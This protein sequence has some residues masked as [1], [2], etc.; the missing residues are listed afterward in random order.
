MFSIITPTVGRSTLQKTCESVNDQTCK[1]WEHLV[2]FDGPEQE[3]EVFKKI[4]HPQRR[5][6]FSGKNFGDYG[7]S[8]RFFAWEL[9]KYPYLMYIDDDDYYHQECLQVIKSNLNPDVNFAFF[10]CRRF[11]AKFLKL[12]PRKNATVSCQYVHKKIDEKGSSIRFPPGGHGRD[13]WWIQKM[14]ETYSYQ[15]IDPDC[16]MV[17]VDTI[18]DGAHEDKPE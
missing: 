13:S 18:S 3:I 17:Y 9:A 15:V 16:P 1:D 2:I 11:G 6:I 4:E 14:V 5:I 7:H 10:P 8:I 12:P